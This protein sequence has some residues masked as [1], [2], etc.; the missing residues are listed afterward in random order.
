MRRPSTMN[1]TSL[2]KLLFRVIS[3][4]KL[5]SKYKK[6][7]GLR[8][9]LAP[10]FHSTAVGPGKIVH[11]G[12]GARRIIV[13]ARTT[14]RPWQSISCPGRLKFCYIGRWSPRTPLGGALAGRRGAENIPL[15][16]LSV[17]GRKEKPE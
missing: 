15:L 17:M 12:R 14:G 8:A 11:C 6:M 9:A 1:R 5:R 10:E 7:R 16:T 2:P 4:L 3:L 13:I